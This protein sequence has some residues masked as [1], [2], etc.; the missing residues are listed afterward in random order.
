MGGDRGRL[1]TR[2]D[3]DWE[4]GHRAVVFYVN[5]TP[6]TSIAGRFGDEG[7]TPDGL[8]EKNETENQKDPVEVHAPRMPQ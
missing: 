1:T 2:F 6:R 5:R 8:V 7:L 3:L 4:E